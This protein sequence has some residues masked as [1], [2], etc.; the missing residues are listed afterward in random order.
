MLENAMTAPLRLLC[1]EDNPADML[2]IERHL[3]KNGCAATCRRVDSFAELSEAL[4]EDW[5]AVLSDYSVPGMDFC[6]SLRYI[7]AHRPNLPLILVSGSVG[8]ETSVE[9]LKHGA[10]DFILKD[11][12]SRLLPSIR[13]SINEADEHRVR[14]EAEQALAVNEAK[15]RAYFEQAPILLLVADAQGRFIDANPTAL[16]TLCYDLASL[17]RLSIAD[18]VIDED[19]EKALADFAISCAGDISGVVEG[20]YRL[21]RQDGAMLWV[22]LRGASIKDH[23]IIYGKDISARKKDEE[24]LRLMAAVFNATQEG[25]AVTDLQGRV[26]AVNAAFTTITE[27]PEADI[28][29]LRL[30]VLNSGRHEPSFFQSMWRD[31][32]DIGYWQGEVW[33][34]RKGGDIYPQWLTISTVLDASGVAEKFVGVFTDISRIKHATTYLEH[35]AHHDALT[36]LPNRLLLMP[37]LQ[38]SL[39]RLHRNGGQGAILFL[40]LDRFKEVNDEFGHQAGDDLLKQVAGRLLSR[41]R[42]IDTVARLGGDEFVIVIED[43]ESPDV[44]AG[45]AQNIIDLLNMPFAL[46]GGERVTIGCSIGI[47]LFPDDGSSVAALLSRADAALYQVKRIGRNTFR[48]YQP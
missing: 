2:L 48:F 11:N 21:R 22:A 17:A 39:D 23:F 14:V 5:D 26:L 12:L 28:L 43:M 25:I 8:E 44:A 46:D 32:R 42:D 36:D 13:R 30:N 41:M 33:D 1:I 27:Y 45:L 40:D 7:Q 20:E 24:H 4:G 3:K 19:R 18:I 16:K 31:L 34:R 38:Y 47:C 10:W 35:L 37:R 29:G 9:L 15:F 6:E